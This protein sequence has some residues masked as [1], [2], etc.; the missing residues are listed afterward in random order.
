MSDKSPLEEYCDACDLFEEIQD[1]YEG[2]T[3]QR[4]LRAQKVVLQS[5]FQRLLETAESRDPAVWHA[6]GSAFNNGRGTTRD[7]AQAVRWFQ[8][9]AEAGHPPAM[10]DL[11]LRLQYPNWTGDCAGAAR[12]FRKAAEKGDPNGMVFLAFSYRDGTGV[13]CDLPEALR[14]FIKAVEAGDGHSMLHVGRMY[15]YYL[16]S[17]AQAVPWFLR[18][19]EAG[20]GESFILLARL[21][22]DRESEVYNPTE[23][24]K[25]FRVV[26]EYRK[27]PIPPLCWNSPGSTSLA[28]AF[29]LT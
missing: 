11:G 4:R 13:P 16:S 15:A 2:P 3:L 27:E 19:A 23:A 9:A 12:W 14:W 25:W 8:R 6:L 1:S 22:D 10:V 29:R 24:N 28:A 18:A 17:P 26:A 5:C 21:Y 7:V 20:F